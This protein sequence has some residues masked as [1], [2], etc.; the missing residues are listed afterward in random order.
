MKYFNFL[1]LVSFLSLHA[2]ILQT[3]SNDYYMSQTTYDSRTNNNA[4]MTQEHCWYEQVPIT[5]SS[6]T[7]NTPNIGGAIVGG[8]IGGVVGHQFGSGSGNSAATIAGAA[9]GT[10]LGS[11]SSNNSS[12]PSYQM[13]KKCNR[14]E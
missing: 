7:N 13:V 5:G 6:S 9:I 2:D 1:L 3:D 4:V 11:Q 14:I 12:T 8:I 10:A